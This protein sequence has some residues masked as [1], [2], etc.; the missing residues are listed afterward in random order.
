MIPDKF[1]VKGGS[2]PFGFHYHSLMAPEIF[3]MCLP[4]AVV[5]LP[6]LDLHLKVPPSPSFAPLIHCRLD[7]TP[8]IFRTA[9]PAIHVHR[10]AKLLEYHRLVEVGSFQLMGIIQTIVSN[11]GDSVPART[12]AGDGV[13]LLLPLVPGVVSEER[14]VA[15]APARGK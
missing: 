14:E 3:T 9:C 12:L 8:P 15:A 13:D 2:S 7:T 4:L 11:L 6:S 1:C 5:R 10:P